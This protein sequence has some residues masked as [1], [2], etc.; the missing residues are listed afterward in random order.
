MKSLNLLYIPWIKEHGDVLL[1]DVA[2]DADDIAL[3]PVQITPQGDTVAR[4]AL[5]QFA[6][7]APRTYARLF[8]RQFLNAAPSAHALALTLDWT[9]PMRIAAEV[10]QSH[11]VPVIVIPH[12]GVFME[13]WRYYRDPNTG[14]DAPIADRLLAWGHGQKDIFT[15]RGYP[16]ERISVVGS[17]KLQKAASY[18]PRLTR[19]EYCSRLG[20]APER[21]IVMF[22]AQTLD[23]VEA[24]RTARQ[25]QARAVADLHDVC[26]ERDYQLILRLPAIQQGTLLQDTFD[27]ALGAHQALTIA[28]P[29]GGGVEAT[30]AEATWH[31]DCVASFGSTMLLE[32][33]LM[34]GPSL[35]TTYIEEVT[36]FVRNGGLPSVETKAEI[37]ALLPELMSRGVRSFPA[38]GWARLEHEF[39]ADDFEDTA[40]LVRIREALRAYDQSVDFSDLR[41]RQTGGLPAPDLLRAGHRTYRRVETDL[42]NRFERVFWKIVG[43]R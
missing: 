14:A 4:R 35:A 29:D 16:A 24:P 23:N 6:A 18:A 31:A 22:C 32:K 27:E 42:V 26:R 40:A 15:K 5:I 8:E 11:G 12:E 38:D 37:E 9:P 19:E 17:P 33:G 28:R 3:T 21:K 39:S 10:A 43:V 34:N 7:N 25:M 20:L 41:P 1:H 2:K 13:E 36:P 30:P